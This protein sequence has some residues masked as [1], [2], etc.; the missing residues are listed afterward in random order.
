[1]IL[2]L[3]RHGVAEDPAESSDKADAKRRLTPKGKSRVADVAHFLDTVGMKPTHFVSS[4]RLRALETAQIVAERFRSKKDV[5]R[6]ASLD[7]AGDWRTLVSDLEELTGKSE[8][9]VV[10]AA[11]HEPL[12]GEFAALA[13]LPVQVSLPVKKGAVVVLGWKGP[14]RDREASL[15]LYL[16]ARAARI[17]GR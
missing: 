1:M 8:D 17:P 10:L 12:C 5:Q 9:A 3:M 14:I 16:T 2:L 4:P 15:L 6:L 11:G 7:F 13:L